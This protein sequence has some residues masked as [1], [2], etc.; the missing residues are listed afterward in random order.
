M[1]T[2][3][4]MTIIGDDRPGLVDQLAEIIVD[5]EGNWLESQLAHLANKFTG[6]VT[7][8]VPT[9]NA[10][11]LQSAAKSINGLRVHVEEAADSTASATPPGKPL[12]LD[13][14]GQD[15]LGI[16]RKI[17]HCLAE[18]G[19]NVEKLHSACESAPMSGEQLFRANIQ[20]R[21]PDGADEAAIHRE[22]EK[23]ASDLMVDISFSESEAE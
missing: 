11:A 17:A 10:D 12:V 2:H 22:I 8:Q 15:R 6:I 20:A 14:I 16:V 3:L 7:V 9:E 21:L 5:H 18:C 23:I 1:F 4:V 13:I 19:V